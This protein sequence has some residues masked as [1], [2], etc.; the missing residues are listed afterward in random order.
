MGCRGSQTG[1]LLFDDCRVPVETGS[2]KEN[3]GVVV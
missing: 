2:A 3:A 1:E